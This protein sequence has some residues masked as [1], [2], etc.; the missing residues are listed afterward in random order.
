MIMM[1]FIVVSS[2]KDKVVFSILNVSIMDINSLILVGI[3]IS[4]IV[5]DCK[6]CL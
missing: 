1:L 5:G 3:I 6:Y 2:E 4:N